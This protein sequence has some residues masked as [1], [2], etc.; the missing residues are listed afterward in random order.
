M[1][2]VALLTSGQRPFAKAVHTNLP[3][4][5]NK[6]HLVVVLA[7]KPCEGFR[8]FEAET[9][10]P[11]VLLDYD[12]QGRAE[13]DA[14]IMAAL[15]AHQ[16]DVVLL[17]YDRLV[18]A[19]LLAAYEGRV[20]NHHMALLPAFK[21]LG[22]PRRTYGHSTLFYGSTI[23]VV[24]QAMDEGP[25]VGQVV[26]ARE[27]GESFAT[28]EARHFEHTVLL[29]LDFLVR[30]GLDTLL[31]VDNQPRFEQ[32]HYGQLPFNPA[33]CIDTGVVQWAGVLQPIGAEVPAS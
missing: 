6:T 11:T 18:G 2:R 31:M 12:A 16:V 9:D 15:A 7:D 8:Y 29:C 32:A 3:R 26:L 5:T 19:E 24:N 4:L 22:A 17:N 14:R 25:I 30:I 21:G 27:P 1:P 20:F 13:N 33:L 28:F 23:H 10:I